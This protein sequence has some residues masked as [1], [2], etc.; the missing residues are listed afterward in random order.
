MKVDDNDPRSPYL[1]VA[2]DLRTAIREGRLPPGTRLPSGRELATEYGVALMTVQ[3]A[4]DALKDDGLVRAHR[5]RGVFVRSS[6]E[7]ED[8]TDSVEELKAE[9]A[10]LRKRVEALEA[11]HPSGS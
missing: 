10:E 8:P 5:G 3:R 6:S 11:R 9:V 4:M 7:T 2:D 1:Q